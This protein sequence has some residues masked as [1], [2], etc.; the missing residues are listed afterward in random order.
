MTIFT[1]F[2][3][4][5]TLSEKRKMAFLILPLT[6]GMLLEIVSIGM[7][8]PAIMFMSTPNI[9]EVYPTLDPI[10]SF[11]GNPDQVTLVTY[12]MLLLVGI[13]C[14]KT[15]FLS[16]LALKQ[17]KLV[18]DIRAALSYRLFTGYLQQSWAF[19]LERNSAQ[20]IL[21]AFNEVNELVSTALLPG[22]LL[23]SEG[24][25]LLGIVI[26]LFTI[27]P[28]GTSL[29]VATI[30]MAA[31]G[32]QLL[33]RKHILR[34]GEERQYYDGLRIQHLQ[35]GLGGV[36]DVKLLGRE[37]E[38]YARYQIHN[39][40]SSLVSQRQKTFLEFPR[41]WL[42]LLAVIGL[43]VLVMVM[44]SQGKSLDGIL[45]T[46]GLF[47]AA[48]FRVLPS[49]NRV[50]GAIQA[51]RYGI[52]V[53]NTLYHEIVV[54]APIE[55]Q[56]QQENLSFKH[57]I[58]L[59]Q[60]KFC[61]P[62]TTNEALN[63]INIMIPFGASVGI[64]GISGAGKSTLVDI[65]LGL[66]SP[67]SGV[68]KVDGVDI[69]SNLRGWQD[70][71]G[72][73]PQSIYLSDDTLRCNI[74]FG[75]SEE[76]IDENAIARAIKSAQLDEF[77]NS[78]PDGLN[79]K[80]G[81]RGVRLSGGQ[82]QRIGIARALYHDPAILVLDEATSALDVNT[83]KEVMQAITA[84][85]GKKTLIIIA[86]RLSTV[87]NCDCLYKMEKGKIIQQGNFEEVTKATE[88]LL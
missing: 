69:Q 17:N 19:H 3:E 85:Q 49:V 57:C 36:K 23:I 50:L 67:D 30:G 5:L 83:E 31:I 88:V 13:Y 6:I 51:L 12:G 62:Q 59:E 84:L 20:L 65:L 29:I 60:I 82:R 80:V 2:C 28:F 66:L 24:L 39:L 55:K 71:I 52:P 27:Q 11:L 68:V 35:Q 9:A 61:Y 8:I 7:V 44:I 1:K 81:E 45:P 43:S 18:F 15:L 32:F 54:L 16:F 73:V 56:Y 87:S 34:W 72:Y 47:A 40:R 42:E 25:V 79:T 14:I 64:T 58:S 74:A 75:L 33:I 78:L 48:A 22:I 38:F 53:I 41:L 46:L 26:V 63:N 21:N 37:K 70:Q 77:I 4:L 86:H 10:L 76:I